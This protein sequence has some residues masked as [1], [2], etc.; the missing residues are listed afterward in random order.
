M[1]RPCVCREVQL[2]AGS[3]TAPRSKRV[4]HVNTS[5]GPVWKRFSARGG[6]LPSW[7][8]VQLTIL[9]TAAAVVMVVIVVVSDVVVWEGKDKADAVGENGAVHNKLSRKDNREGIMI[10]LCS[11]GCCLGLWMF[12]VVDVMDVVVVGLVVVVA[13]GRGGRL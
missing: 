1:L 9:S 3:S 4:W 6:A 13:V 12:S 2:D 7:Q 10:F 5:L 8:I 11:C